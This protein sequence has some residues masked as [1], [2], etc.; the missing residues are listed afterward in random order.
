MS[1]S[2]KD[3]AL[4]WFDGVWQQRSKSTIPSLLAEGAHAHQ[5][6][7]GVITG[8]EEFAQFHDQ[9]V[10]GFP[11]VALQVLHVVADDQQ[12]AV[13]WRVSGTH[14]GTFLGLP[15]SQ[16]AV[17]FDGMTLLTVTDGKITEGWDCWDVGSL[18][19]RLAEGS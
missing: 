13:H 11:D 2:P 19:G 7:G 4:Q 18:M 14:R 6:S 8:P 9:I 15:A 5:P 3:I 17:S 1:S 16:K 10:A 12:A